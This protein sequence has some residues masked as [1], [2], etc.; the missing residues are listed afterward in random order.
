MKDWLNKLKGSKGSSWLLLALLLGVLLLFPLSEPR[1]SGMTDEEQRISATLSAIAG[2]GESR[3]TIYYAPAEK[4]FGA[5]AAMPQGAVILSRGAN[6]IAVRL[7]LLRA[8]ETLLQLPADRIEIFP[9][10]E[11]E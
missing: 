3:I 10:E 6:D 7:Q 2:A 9:M 5:S 1:E 11:A 8:A 4:G